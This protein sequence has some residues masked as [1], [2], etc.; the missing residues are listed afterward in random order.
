[1]TRRQAL[2]M[3]DR[4]M[5]R[6]R[7]SQS[8]RTIGRLMKQKFGAGLNLAN[9]S[10]ADALQELSQIGDQ[11]PTIGSMAQTLGID[12]SRA[13]R[14]TAAAIRAGFVKRIA[15]QS[16]GRSSHLELTTEGR[17]A[18]E[19]TRRFRLRFFGQLLS[20]WSD[21]ECAEFGRLLIRF[22][23]SLPGVS[24]DPVQATKAKR[25]SIAS[26]RKR[27]ATQ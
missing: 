13:S 23:D 14:M 15:S 5:V 2:S 19:L 22:T 16:D 10:I 24:S 17:K 1:M 20:G 25:H 7:R 27:K 8:R 11:R 9:I 4:A 18:L 26:N 6:I 12:P 3:V 21:R